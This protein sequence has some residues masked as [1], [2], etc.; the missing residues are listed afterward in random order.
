MNSGNN[1]TYN[2]PATF[3]AGYAGASKPIYVFAY[4]HADQSNGQAWVGAWTAASSL[5]VSTA[6]NIIL[7]R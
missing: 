4:D 5:P 7:F 1:W 3:A 2:V 6:D